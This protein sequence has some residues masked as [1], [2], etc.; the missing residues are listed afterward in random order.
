MTR[1]EHD[2]ARELIT[3]GEALPAAQPGLAPGPYR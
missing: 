1:N 3:L 2:E